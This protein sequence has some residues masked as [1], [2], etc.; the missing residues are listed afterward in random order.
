MAAT[1]VRRKSVGR[2]RGTFVPGRPLF[3]AECPPPGSAE[4]CW[5]ETSAPD[6]ANRES[7]P[8]LVRMTSLGG[9]ESPPHFFL[10]PHPLPH[11]DKCSEERRHAKKKIN[12]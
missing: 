9:V 7:R 5:T 12:K 2:L 8:R 10:L 4:R 11:R 3:K 6:T 1:G